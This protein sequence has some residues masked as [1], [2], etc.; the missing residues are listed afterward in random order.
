MPPQLQPANF[1]H[2]AEFPKVLSGLG[3]SLLVS[4]YQA[5]QV[6]AFGTVGNDLSV[7]LESF[8]V[9]MGI[10]VHPA[11]VA[12]GSKGIIW[13]LD[14]AGR[15]LANQFP[16][17][18]AHDA[19]L[20]TR[21]CHVTGNIHSHEM[22]FVGDELWV[23]NTL[24]SCLA[25]LQPKYHFVPRWKPPFISNC[26]VPG[27]RCHLNG[28]AVD[29]SDP[30]YVTAMAETDTP[31]G[32]RHAK[33]RTGVLI[34]VRSGETVS[35]GFAMPH[36]PRI[37]RN[38]VWALDSGRGHLV[39]IDIPS[40]KWDVVSAFPGY[41]RGLAFL[42]DYAFVGLS[43]MRETSVF[44]GV[45]LSEFRDKL[46]CGIGVVNI[47]SGQ[48]VAAFQFMS[49]I[50]E[51]FDVQALPTVRNPLVRSHLSKDEEGKMIWTTPPPQHDLRPARIKRTNEER[52]TPTKEEP[53][54]FHAI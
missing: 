30:R 28:L 36:S 12:V 52:E 19:A 45:P 24:F 39:V 34:D 54:A 47:R 9:A 29:A 25:T 27:D 53:I 37:Y 33:E 22:A 1:S 10:A 26:H 4:T 41:T 16:P 50:N 14:S 42:G 35:R 7:A 3:G 38:R 2:T 18:G 51:I 31:S 48:Q 23:V 40:G 11:R 44:G 21:T 6:C 49:G 5:G 32:W 8:S 20:L 15:D 46:Q 13:F 17:A 43:R